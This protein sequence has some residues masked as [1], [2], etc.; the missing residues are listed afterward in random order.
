MQKKGCDKEVVVYLYKN[1]NYLT[2]MI[3]DNHEIL[4]KFNA[5]QDVF[6]KTPNPFFV[7]TKQTDEN[8]SVKSV[9]LYL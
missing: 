3:T 5:K 6:W 8:I 2:K 4:L 9:N 7:T 1:E